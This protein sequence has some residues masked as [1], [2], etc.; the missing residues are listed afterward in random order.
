MTSRKSLE[1]SIVQAVL[2]AEA[3]LCLARRTASHQH[4]FKGVE[5]EDIL[6]TVGT[7]V[8]HIVEGLK[9][10]KHLATERLQSS[11]H[12]TDTAKKL[13][14]IARR[15]ARRVSMLAKSEITESLPRKLQ[16]NGSCGKAEVPTQE[17]S[18]S[19]SKHRLE[20]GASI[21]LLG[22]STITCLHPS[23]FSGDGPEGC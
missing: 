7:E 17:V 15:V 6:D 12:S 14:P 2:E 5:L 23:K 11:S 18:C 10:R 16:V 9:L 4:R 3:A 20:A 13:A 8:G 19:A 21:G 22:F 1:G